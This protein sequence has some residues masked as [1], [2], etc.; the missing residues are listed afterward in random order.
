MKTKGGVMT[1]GHQVVFF[2]ACVAATLAWSPIASAGQKYYVSPTGNDNADG[3]TKKKAW[4]TLDR[5]AM[6]TFAAKDQ[7]L[8]EAGGVFQGSIQLTPT[9]R[10]VTSRLERTITA[11]RS[12]MRETARASSSRT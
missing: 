5:V 9:T 7:L 10:R 1:R 6:H 12:S 3:T 2:T 11:A 4:R 8:L